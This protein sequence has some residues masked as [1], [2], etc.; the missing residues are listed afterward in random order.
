MPL[1]SMR[2]MKLARND[3]FDNTG[4][5]EMVSEP[6]PE[7]IMLGYFGERSSALD[8]EQSCCCS[9]CQITMFIHFLTLISHI[10]TKY[11]K[12]TA[13]RPGLAGGR[14]RKGAKGR[15]EL[16]AAC[17]NVFQFVQKVLHSWLLGPLL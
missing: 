8:P 7:E 16:Y 6:E 15:A 9:V 11:V 5:E 3:A 12:V 2:D 14:A 17:Y 1:F 10:G 13:E 4:H